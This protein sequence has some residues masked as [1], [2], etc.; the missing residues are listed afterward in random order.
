MP[1]SGDSFSYAQYLHPNDIPEDDPFNLPPAHE[2]DDLFDDLDME[3][4]PNHDGADGSTTTNGPFGSLQQTTSEN[5]AVDD[6]AS[7]SQ[8]SIENQPEDDTSSPASSSKA[9]RDNEAIDAES[10]NTEASPDEITDTEMSN[11]ITPGP[12]GDSILNDEVADEPTPRAPNPGQRQGR[13]RK[14]PCSNCR[15]QGRLKSESTIQAHKVADKI[16]KH[17][18]LEQPREEYKACSEC[19]RLIIDGKSHRHIKSKLRKMAVSVEYK[20]VFAEGE[21]EGLRGVAAEALVAMFTLKRNDELAAHNARLVQ[22]A[23][24]EHTRIRGWTTIN[25]PA[26]QRHRNADPVP[27][28]DL[29]SSTAA[30]TPSLVLRFRG[31][32][33]P[34]EDEA[35][36]PSDSLGRPAS[37]RR[38]LPT[39]RPNTENQQPQSPPAVDPATVSNAVASAPQTTTVASA[40]NNRQTRATTGAR[41]MCIC[42]SCKKLDTVNGVGLVKAV[43]TIVE[44]IRADEIIAKG[45]KAEVPCNGCAKG[46]HGDD[47]FYDGGN[48]CSACVRKKEKC[49]FS[50]KESKGRKRDQGKVRQEEAP[51][52]ADGEGEDEG[53]DEA[54]AEERSEVEEPPKKKQKRT[55]ASRNSPQNAQLPPVNEE[56]VEPPQ[57][58]SRRRPVNR[59]SYR[60]ARQQ[61]VEPPRASSRGGSSSVDGSKT[62]DGNSPATS[63]TADEG[64]QSPSSGTP[65]SP[66]GAEESRAA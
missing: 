30:Q 45:E 29:G 48:A 53:E 32:N 60:P 7:T 35:R 66:P 51:G 26:S 2:D 33:E 65:G 21:E 44:H 6:A 43:K 14:C 15:G 39:S 12:S 52:N 20:P 17:N 9:T 54:N 25:A 57:A 61:Q 18:M 42:S 23:V 4:E 63:G 13:K 59:R 16:E 64:G 55:R 56:A 31:I 28:P 34:T 3:N 40:A 62:V 1:N 24:P 47:C 27:S 58:T 22:D 49:S 19:S 11:A 10:P 37:A 36:L 5:D 41:E 50:K 46:N 38:P 8:A